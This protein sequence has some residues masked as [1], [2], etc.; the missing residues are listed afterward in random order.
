LPSIQ[1]SNHQTCKPTIQPENKAQQTN[2]LPA[3]QSSFTLTKTINP[4]LI[5]RSQ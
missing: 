2:P 4:F 1:A 5:A 3:A